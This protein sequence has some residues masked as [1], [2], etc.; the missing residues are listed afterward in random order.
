MM[1]V[2]GS[3]ELNDLSSEG[4]PLGGVGFLR[5][6]VANPEGAIVR[7]MQSVLLKLISDGVDI[8]EKG[9]VVVQY[10][11][12][13]LVD[14]NCKSAPPEYFIRPQQ[15]VSNA[16]VDNNSTNEQLNKVSGELNELRGSRP[17]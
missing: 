16:P 1:Q 5:A 7:H 12:E 11:R 14:R 8:G 17:H 9:E 6:K 10:A 13:W 3:K 4:E 15:E 2:N